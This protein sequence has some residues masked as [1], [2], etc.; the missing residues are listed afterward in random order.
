MTLRRCLYIFGDSKLVMKQVT[1]NPNNPNN[2]NN[3][4]NNPYITLITLYNS[5]NPLYQDIY[6]T[7]ITLIFLITLIT[8]MD[9]C[10]RDIHSYDNPDIP[11]M[12]P[13][14]QWNCNHP[15]LQPLCQ[16]AR[17]KIHRLETEFH[18]HSVT[19]IA[20]ITLTAL[21]TFIVLYKILGRS[22]ATR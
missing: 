6:I 3:P 15:K 20:L 10:S 11:S 1:G 13:L 5:I 21:I 17:R 14:A 16:D 4:R 7:L 22:T 2:P 19:L 12:N 8:L 18:C 9:N